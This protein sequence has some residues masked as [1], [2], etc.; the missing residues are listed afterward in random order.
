MH[1]IWAIVRRPFVLDLR[2]LALLRMGKA[3]VVL[4]NLVIR[5]ID[6]EAHYSNL[7]VLPIGALVKHA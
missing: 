5:S 3:A 6:L 4:L 1:Q 2:A 7:G